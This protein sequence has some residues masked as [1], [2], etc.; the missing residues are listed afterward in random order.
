MDSSATADTATRVSASPPLRD[1]MEDADPSL[2]RKRPRLDC[3]SIDNSAMHLQKDSVPHTTAPTEQLVEMTI[4]SQPPLSS[5]ASDTAG[6]S[7]DGPADTP[8]TED[9]PTTAA[10]DGTLDRPGDSSAGSPPVIAISDD[11]ADDAMSDYALAA[12]FQLDFDADAHLSMFPYVNNGQY[13]HAATEI[14]KYYHSSTLPSSIYAASY[15]NVLADSQTDGSILNQLTIWLD[16]LP[17]DPLTW[18]DFY[19]S[20]AALWD[21]ICAIAGR[22]VNRR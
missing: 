12:S 16:G 1:S 19:F 4:R 9:V 20:Q 10:V 14:A 7:Q 21:E 3:G 22:I 15:A 5:H 2:T 18:L 13:L 11:D 6:S 17:H 8:L